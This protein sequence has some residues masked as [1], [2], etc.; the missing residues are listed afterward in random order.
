MKTILLAALALAAPAFAQVSPQA[1]PAARAANQQQR[2]EAGVAQGDLTHKETRKLIKQQHRVEAREQ[3][4]RDRHGG[5][6]T[7]KDQRKLHKQ[8]NH[9][10][11]NIHHARTDDDV[12]H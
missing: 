6:L 2:I 1:A 8:Q 12:R 9:L 10:S 7:R 4:M 3:I 11:K 5:Y